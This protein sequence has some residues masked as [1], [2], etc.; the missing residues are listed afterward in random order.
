MPAMNRRELLAASGTALGAALVSP[1][2][3]VAATNRAGM[4]YPGQPWLEETG[5]RIHA[6][7]GSILQVGSTYFWYG[8]NKE[9]T[10]PGS[11]VW[12]WGMRMYSSLDLMNWKDRGL[13]IPPD[14]H[15]TQSTF[16]PSSFTDRPHIVFN[17]R[18][19]KYV[20]WAK[21][22]HPGDWS[23]TRTFMISRRHPRS[24]AI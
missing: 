10:L 12:Q 3:V 24:E 6:H 8:E 22:M 18:T 1:G 4:I 15:N 9:R 17:K 20:C 11:G 5:K 19:N 23:Q 21:H 2:S 16:A 13:F 7:G 14:L